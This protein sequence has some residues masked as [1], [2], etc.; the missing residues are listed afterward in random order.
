MSNML[1]YR[2]LNRE[3]LARRQGKPMTLDINGVEHLRVVHQDV[4]LE[5][6]A[7]SFQVHMQINQEQAVRFYNASQILCAPI[8]AISANSPYLFGKD[9][10]DETRIPLF[11]QAVAIG[12]Y[13]GA[14]FGPI[15]RVTFG[16]GYLRKELMEC[17]SEN[18]EHYPIL[19]PE[20]LHQP[21][22][23]F[24]HVSLHNG[25]IW[26]WN[27]PLIGFDDHGDIHLRIEHRI[28]PAGPSTL[29]A[30]ANAAFYYGLVTALANETV[31]PESQLA[32]SE[33]RDNF[34]RCAQLGLRAQVS[35]RDHKR[36]AVSDLLEH[37]LLPAAQRGLRM[38]D[39]AEDD[40]AEY[41]RIIKERLQTRTNGAAWQRAFV[42]K[43]GRDM[44]A[45]TENYFSQQNSGNPVHEWSV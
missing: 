34:Y 2:V 19:L 7:T 24:A 23:K 4:M 15:H 32:F 22:Q 42:Q 29:D 36:H 14:A 41:L 17:F 5:S 20:T 12:G 31:P 11:E 1:R 16:S 13:E 9:L 6:A 3:V 10:W 26:R 43:Y 35:W 25:T 39:I 18:L 33:A 37:V 45:L 30:I 27:R 8:M 44:L 21:E 40:S 38:L 28:I